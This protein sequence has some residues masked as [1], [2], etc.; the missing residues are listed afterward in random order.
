MNRAVQNV[1]HCLVQLL[2]FESYR[3][4]IRLTARGLSEG[5]GLKAAR[6]ENIDIRAQAR[7]IATAAFRMQSHMAVASDVAAVTAGVSVP[8]MLEIDVLQSF[9]E[10]P[11]VCKCVKQ[12]AGLPDRH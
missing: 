7:V 8:S 11:V 3:D 10:S 1:Y 6:D 12:P 5:E 4:L 9:T 2:I